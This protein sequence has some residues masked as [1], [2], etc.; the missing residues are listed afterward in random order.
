ML[1]Q[2]VHV[3]LGSHW[4]PTNQIKLPCSSATLSQDGCPAHRIPFL[5]NT[6]IKT[7]MQRSGQPVPRQEC[8]SSVG[9]AH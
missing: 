4:K 1:N 9:A 5:R 7:R 3:G 8:V 2:S 6:G